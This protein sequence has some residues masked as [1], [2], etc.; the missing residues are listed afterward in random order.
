[1][2]VFDLLHAFGIRFIILNML[3]HVLVIQA[4]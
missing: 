1:M 3:W 4:V 2:M